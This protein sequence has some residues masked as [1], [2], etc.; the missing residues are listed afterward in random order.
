MFWDVKD[1]NWLCALQKSLSFIVVTTSTA[2]VDEAIC[3][4]SGGMCRS[5]CLGDQRR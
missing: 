1:F 4:S 5:S 2:D 3:S